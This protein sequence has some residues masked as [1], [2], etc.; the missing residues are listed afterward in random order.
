[1]AAGS[2]TFAPARAAGAAVG[3]EA[4]SRTAGG[5]PVLPVSRGP[6][7]VTDALPWEWAEQ[8]LLANKNFWVVTVSASGRPHSLPV[9][10]VWLPETERFWFSCSPHARKARNV[11]DNEVCYACPLGDECTAEI[12][13]KY[14]KKDVCLWRE[15]GAVLD[16]GYDRLRDSRHLY[17]SKDGDAGSTL[18]ASPDSE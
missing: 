8:R 14:L 9:W 6:E 12:R 10:G 3:A 13:Q 16:E 1:M 5:E 4:A 17:R 11:V 7:D 2:S 15:M 18:N